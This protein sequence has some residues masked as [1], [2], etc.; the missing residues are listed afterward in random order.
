V[1]ADE[2]RYYAGMSYLESGEAQLAA[3]EFARLLADYPQSA[4][5]GS[6]LLR[7][8]QAREALGL[9]ERALTAY[10]A[11]SIDFPE[12][13]RAAEGLRRAAELLERT[14][15][16]EESAAAF[17]TLATRYPEDSGAPAARFRAGLNYYR[18]DN[19][20]AAIASWERLL[21]WYPSATQAQAARFWIGKTHL[22]AGETISATTMLNAAAAQAPWSFYGLRASELLA[23]EAPFTPAEGALLP[24]GSPAEQAEAEAWLINWLGLDPATEVSALSPTLQSDARLQR[25]ALLLRAGYFD[26]AR[27][28]LEA[29]RTQHD[30]DPLAQYQLALWFRDIGLYRSSIIAASTI[31]QL[32]PTSEITEVPRFLGCLSYPTYYAELV[33]P[34]AAEFDLDPLVIYALIRQESLFEGFATSHAAAHGLMQVIPPTGQEI[35][36]ALGWP[37]NYETRD[38]YRPLV[39]VRFG[40]WYL[41]RQRDRFAGALTPALAGYN[42]GPGN[43]ARWLERAGGDIDLFTELIAFNETRT[44]VERLTEHY[45]RYQW[46]YTA[47]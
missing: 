43:A 21:A 30:Y 45:A 14:G 12:H 29:V 10:E 35:H 40:A 24:C 6:A 33:E 7:L 2:P 27:T 46:L 28:E 1:P 13:P 47:P 9:T 20:T 34:N 44:Y 37:P 16:L 38:L 3:E 18:A 25:G 8:G 32:H 11:V 5:A 17:E 22:V 4:Y 26:Q 19:P 15:A 39:S 41:A 23:G 36:A 31:R 42:G